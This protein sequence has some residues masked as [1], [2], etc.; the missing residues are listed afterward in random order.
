VHIT[1]IRATRYESDPAYNGVR[2]GHEEDY[3]ISYENE[4]YQRT[5]PTEDHKTRRKHLPQTTSW[6]PIRKGTKCTHSRK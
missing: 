5:E 4:V 3:T 6:H 2:D 1:L